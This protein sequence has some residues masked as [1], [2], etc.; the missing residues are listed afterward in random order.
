MKMKRPMHKTIGFMMV[1][2]L[3]CLFAE[4]DPRYL[5]QVPYLHKTKPRPLTRAMCPWLKKI[6]NGKT[7]TRNTDE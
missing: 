5:I 2:E 7:K 6:I 1:M 4:M 3:Y